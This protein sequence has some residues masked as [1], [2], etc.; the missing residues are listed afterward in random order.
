M[1]RKMGNAKK[2]HPYFQQI[3]RFPEK[4][5]MI[6]LGI[7]LLAVILRL[8]VDPN[9]PFHYDPGKNIV[10]A[11]AALEWFPFVPQYNSFFNLGEYY[12]YQVLFPYIVSFL[13]KISGGSLVQIT[14]WLAI[15]SG[16]ALTVTVYYFT[17]EI[18]NNKTAALISAFLIAVSEIQLIQFMN[19]YPQILAM[20]LMP[21]A[22]L[23]LV[24]Y[25][26]SR[27]LKYLVLTTIV[28]ALIVMGSYLVAMVYFVIVL[29]SLAIWSYFERKSLK[30]LIIVPLVTALLLTFFW[31]P[32]VWRHGLPQ[33]IGTG[34]T[35]IFHTTGT[36]TN[37]PW[38]I[39][40]FLE[41]S[42]GAL[43]AI[44]AVICV[45]ILIRKKGWEKIQ[46]D[47]RKVLLGVWLIT[48][49][50]LME[51]YLFNPILWVD[52]YF[53]L[54]DI[55]V[56]IG[57]GGALCML[58]TYINSI[59]IGP[60]YKGYLLLLL[61]II[62]L[63]SAVF[64]GISIGRWG[65]PSDFALLGYMEQ[66]IP[67]E[68]LVVAPPGIYGFWVSGLSGVRILSGE[69]SQMIGQKYTGTQENYAIIGYW[70][71]DEIINSPDVHRKMELIRQFGVNYIFIPVHED[72]PMVWNPD[73]DQAGIDAF[74]N[75]EYFETEKAYQDY[76]GYSALIKVREDL[77]PQYHVPEIN[78]AVTIA[79]YT[80]SLA[81][82]LGL[83][84]IQRIKKAWPMDT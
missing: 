49:F 63:L 12:E 28:S 52:R 2:S 58:I 43:I 20:T 44:G 13:H 79:G 9:I 19:Y 7:F 67:S 39:L 32:I 69:T 5:L 53:P 30:I 81:T 18:F 47:F 4:E 50:L 66:N 24:R 73:I 45:I 80:I 83:M 62:P 22:L 21:L 25:V 74:R 76:F 41:H 54:F 55:A 37:E 57:V 84:Y 56:I 60:N 59:K 26:R 1:A 61:L 71:S 35:R 36:F 77:E 64:T 14:K 10:Y 11:R 6:L 46:W 70:E 40:T 15:I 16:A 31:L 8:H 3:L 48:T 29:F 51:S 23:F 82:L 42:W 27:E 78:W 38:T 34:V 17:N 72:V 75:P 68:S 65:Y 33:I